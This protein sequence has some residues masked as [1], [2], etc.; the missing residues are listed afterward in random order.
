MADASIFRR[1]LVFADRAR[2]VSSTRVQAYVRGCAGQAIAE[3]VIG[4]A[5]G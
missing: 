2:L 3:L 5:T 4:A 1:S